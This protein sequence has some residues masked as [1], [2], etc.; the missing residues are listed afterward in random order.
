MW[1][2]FDQSEDPRYIRE[3]REYC[4]S[5]SRH[6]KPELVSN[7]LQ[8]LQL[9]TLFE[10]PLDSEQYSSVK[11]VTEK[12]I[13]DCGNQIYRIF[14]FGKGYGWTPLR[15]LW[16]AFDSNSYDIEAKYE[17]GEEDDDDE[18]EEGDEYENDLPKYFSIW[19]LEK[20]NRRLNPLEFLGPDEC[21]HIIRHN[22]TALWQE[23]NDQKDKL[24]FLRDLNTN[25][26]RWYEE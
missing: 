24:K 2:Q 14:S 4:D 20:E 22:I 16:N 9:A 1:K 17:N 11:T 7:L 19:N 8:N 25:I 12:Q 21:K 10:T 5:H 15:G 18:E 6:P 3:W 26:E 23:K 13:K